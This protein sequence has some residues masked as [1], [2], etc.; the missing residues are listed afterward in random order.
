MFVLHNYASI[1]PALCAKTAARAE[2]ASALAQ[3]YGIAEQTVCKWEKRQA[4]TDRLHTARRLQ[5]HLNC[6]Q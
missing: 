4:F 6:T 3:R 5:T 2:P 1:T